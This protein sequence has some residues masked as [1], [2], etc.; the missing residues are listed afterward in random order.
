MLGRGIKTWVLVAALL[1][2]AVEAV[3]LYRHYDRYY[4]ASDAAPG[5]APS[6]A[7]TSGRTM[8]E[9]TVTDDAEA[10]DPDERAANEEASF[11]HRATDENSRGDYTYLDHPSING[12]ADDVVLV[13]PAPDRGNAG[14]GAYDHNI[15]VWYEP[16][17]RKWAIF[18]Q[19]LAAV[20]DGSAFG[21][22]VPP[23]DEGFV[24]RAE[25][26]NTVGN[27][28]Y[29]DDPLL[30]GKPDAEV[31]VTQNWNPGGG[32]G[33]YNDHPVGVLYDE[34]VGEWFVYNEDGARMPEGA[35]F[36]VAVSGDA[37]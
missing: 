29:L 12:D 32:G 19:D 14:G 37:G 26:L 30:D 33:V 18:N 4:Y 1:I 21:V 28:T 20:P 31:S 25:L 17:E 10:T 23:A 13:V 11:V 5:T 7:P 16:G 15:G 22:V 2:L 6:S 3:F 9:G 8:P 27:A 24:H 36:N 35:A 34:D